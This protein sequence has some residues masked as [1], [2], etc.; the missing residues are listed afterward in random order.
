M[1]LSYLGFIASIAL[2]SGTRTQ[3][4]IL[5]LTPTDM[6]TACDGCLAFPTPPF[7][8]V[9]DFF[10]GVPSI[11]PGLYPTDAPPFG[12][13]FEQRGVLEFDLSQ[14]TDADIVSATLLLKIFNFGFASINR[15]VI[16]IYGFT[17]DGVVS[18]SDMTRTN[19]LVDT[20]PPLSIVGPLAPIDV[21]AFVQTTAIQNQPFIA[22][23]FRDVVPESDVGF[24]FTDSVPMLQ[25]TT[26]A[27][28]P[29]PSSIFLIGCGSVWL[30]ILLRGKWRWGRGLPS[31]HTSA[32]LSA[33]EFL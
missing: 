29:E 18:L 3:A 8:G 17:G 2:L 25:I 30:T 12:S 16:E 31:Q 5:T 20:T 7:D 22:F 32:S 1:K 23:L 26:T 15:P 11:D 10:V 4:G 13:P 14:F 21:T 33:S 24:N 19:D 28:I 27:A 9:F 6:Q